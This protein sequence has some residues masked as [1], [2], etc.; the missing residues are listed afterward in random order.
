M[1]RASALFIIFCLAQCAAPVFAGDLATSQYNRGNQLFQE[2][3]F[4]EALTAYQAAIDAGGDDPRLF[5]N[6]G[7]A[8]FRL[9][10]VGLAVWAY[11]MGL[12]LAPRDEDLRFNLRYAEAFMRDD[13]PP[14]DQVFVLRAGRAVAS[15]LTATEATLLASIGWFLLGLAVLLW[16]PWRRY[17]GIVIAIGSLGLLIL[18]VCGPLAIWRLHDQFGVDKAVVVAEEAKVLTAPV[19]D[20]KEAFTVHGGLNLRIIES[21]DRYARVRIPTGLEGWIDRQAF[22]AV[23]K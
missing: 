22:Q 2:N 3:K 13:L 19:P 1:A 20:A 5:L 14:A 11:E 8:A 16:R 4:Q 23:A 17:R 7:N 10:Q 12:R 9:N 18:L 15:R 21:R 6:F